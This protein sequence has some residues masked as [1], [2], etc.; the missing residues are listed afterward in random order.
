MQLNI[1]NETLIEYQFSTTI[2][3]EISQEILKIYQYC[4]HH[5]DYSKLGLLD[6]IPTFNTLA[7]AFD[8]S[9][10][11]FANPDYLQDTLLHARSYPHSLPVTCHH[12]ELVYNGVDID[13]VC[14]SLQLSKESFI[15]LHQQQTYTIAMLGFTG[16]FPYLLGLDKRLT[17]ARKS[18]PRKRVKKGAVAIAANQCGIYPEDS[19]GGWHIIATTLFTDFNR[20]KAGDQ[21]MFRNSDA[22]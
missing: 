21:I 16:Y 18:S 4:L 9:S 14:Q 1:I 20:L 3:L 2:S 13:S 12:I 10:P 19:P 17:L 6:I 11:L 15:Q 7:I 5:L 8:T 22:N